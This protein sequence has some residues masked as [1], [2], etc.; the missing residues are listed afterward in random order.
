MSSMDTYG[1][2]HYM[3][4][5]ESLRS[6]EASHTS[7]NQKTSVNFSVG[8]IYT[9]KT[10]ERFQEL[11]PKFRWQAPKKQPCDLRVLIW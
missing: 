5:L 1:T 7:N 10:P 3:Q 9:G 11:V 8:G 4:A 2:C 6:H